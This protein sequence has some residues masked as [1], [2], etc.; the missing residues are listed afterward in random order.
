M[1]KDKPN[2]KR[3]KK[4]NLIPMDLT[5]SSRRMELALSVGGQVIM[6]ISTNI[7]ST[8]KIFLKK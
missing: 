3:Y 6:H 7:G 5:P 1:V 8:T 2:P 4:K